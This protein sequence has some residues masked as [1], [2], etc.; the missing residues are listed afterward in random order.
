MKDFTIKR[1]ISG[2]IILA[3][4]SSS[5]ILPLNAMAATT[6]S[7]GLNWNN[8]NQSNPFTLNASTLLNANNLMAVVGC[9]GIIDTATDAAMRLVSKVTSKVLNKLIGGG[10]VSVTDAQQ[11]AQQKISDKRQ[12][13]F[14]GL[15]YALA[16]QQLVSMTKS[17]M[18]WVN[19]GF[20]GDP[21]YVRNINALTNSI[22]GT[23][24]QKEVNLFKNSPAGGGDYPYGRDFALS[25]I[26]S[27]RFGQNPSNALKQNL[28]NY[29]STVPGNDRYVES[30]TNNFSLGGWNG[31]L[32]FTQ[33][34]QNNPLGFNMIESEN[35][36]KKQDKEVTNTKAE[37][38]QG[39]GMLD[40]KKCVLWNMIDDA[41]GEYITEDVYDGEN[42]WV[43]KTKTTKNPLPEDECAQYETV[44]PGSLIKDK[45]SKYLN[46][47]ETQLE[48]ADSL[49]E[50]LYSIF[51]NLIS[52]FQQNGLSSLSSTSVVDFSTASSGIGA[53]KIVDENG[54]SVTSGNDGSGIDPSSNFDITTDLGGI[55]TTQ[56][57]YIAT[58][59]KLFPPLEEVMAKLGELDYCI[60][61]PNPNWQ[62]N[63][64][65]AKD[66]YYNWLNSIAVVGSSS[67]F[68]GSSN[69][70][71]TIPDINAA[72][73]QNYISSINNNIKYWQELQSSWYFNLDFGDMTA[74]VS[75]NAQERIT[76]RINPRM[77][78][79][80]KA[81]ADYKIAADALYGFKS[82][83]QTEY[84]NIGMPNQT[85]NPEYLAMAQTGLSITRDINSYASSIGEMTTTYQNRIIETNSNIYKLKK[86][87]EK[88]DIIVNRAQ[89]L[90]AKTRA[91]NGL[92]P[93]TK[94]CLANEKTNLA[95]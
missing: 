66:A 44:T 17:T 2:I 52:R 89:A 57:K 27:F 40:Q 54:V 37:I 93:V 58:V 70:T 22:E 43:S 30:Y 51:G 13:C 74:G 50:V 11:T 92:P 9:T 55:I 47:G 42:G 4:F 60:P 3:F 19:S 6:S 16:K 48:L 29:L 84:L 10:E 80:D 34:P 85:E 24:L 39:G 67:G 73:S 76:N 90:R 61:G 33:M 79:V 75:A 35:L 14:D 64:T 32:A 81:E 95:Q 83:M 1:T 78:E 20:N 18:N 72:A 63:S 65:N 31:W 23:I 46:S 77:D 68:L 59:N 5:F 91:E 36:A 25:Q 82:P 88:I 38:A 21:M 26:N 87:K 49:N 71:I 8:P 53:N 41:T 69:Y 45:V 28:S 94:E 56:Q 86:L 12:A 15:A 62:E 7:K